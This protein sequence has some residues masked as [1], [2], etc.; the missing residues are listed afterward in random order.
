MTEKLNKFK[1]EIFG[2]TNITLHTT[3]FTRQ[4]NGFEKMKERDFCENFYSKLNQLILELDIKIISCAIKKEQ[5]M[6]KIVSTNLVSNLFHKSNYPSNLS[7][8]I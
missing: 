1:K 6:E 5:H 2:T 8:N 7:E 3:D 4:K